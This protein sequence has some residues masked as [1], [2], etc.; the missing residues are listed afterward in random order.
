MSMLA[1]VRYQEKVRLVA[2]AAVLPKFEKLAEVE[3]DVTTT[4]VLMDETAGRQLKQEAIDI[5]LF[6]A[7]PHRPL[8][9]ISTRI[10][11]HVHFAFMK[12]CAMAGVKSRK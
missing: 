5:F 4:K 6:A 3:A 7:T 1:F 2:A 8:N 9:E 12:A 10:R 11:G